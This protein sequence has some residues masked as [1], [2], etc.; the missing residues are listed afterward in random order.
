MENILL[1]SAYVAIETART[2]ACAYHI[3]QPDM[4]RE[5]DL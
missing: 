5:K 4:V 2:F 1:R 3:P